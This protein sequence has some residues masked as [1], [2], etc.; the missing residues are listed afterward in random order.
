MNEAQK[1]TEDTFEPHYFDAKALRLSRDSFGKLHLTV[2]DERHE[3]VRPARL[4]P[5]S[6]PDKE[7]AF[8]NAEGKEIGILKEVKALDGASRGCLE[9]ELA[10][11]YFTPIITGI[12]VV[13][14][15]FGVTSW[16]VDTDHGP[17]TIHVKDRSDI[18]RLPGRRVILIDVYG[19]KHEIPDYNRLDDRSRSLLEAEI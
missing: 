4:F 14:A 1:S 8:Q 17:R 19:L 18:R 11:I 10:L 16:E 13:N 12:K 9:D 5:I 15:R 3:G 2:N 7:I 6:L